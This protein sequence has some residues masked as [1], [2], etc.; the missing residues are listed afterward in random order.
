[1]HGSVLGIF[2]L[3]IVNRAEVAGRDV[4]EVGS[5][6]V[7]GSVR[8]ILAAHHPR[9]YLG[10]D[11]VDGPGVD[12]VLDAKQLAETFGPDSFDIVVCCET[13]EHVDDW[14][15]VMVNLVEVL[16]PGGALIITTRSVGFAY[17]HPPDTFRYT[18]ASFAAMAGRFALDVRILVDD[19]EFPGVFVK[20]RKPADWARPECYDLDDVP[21]ITRTPLPVKVLGL[22][23]YPDGTAYYRFS[24]PFTELLR[25]GHNVHIPGPAV[26]FI[27]TPLAADADVVVQQRAH[28]PD[29]WARLARLAGG[30]A[31]IYETDDHILAPD[32]SGLDGWLDP[33]LRAATLGCLR[34]ADLV[35]TSTEL[36]AEALRAH[37]DAE[38]VVLPDCVEAALLTVDPTRHHNRDDPDRE[39]VVWWAGANNHLQDMMVLHEPMRYLA[40]DR[41]DLHLMGRDFRPLLGGRGR[42]T[43]WRD[44]I[45][46]YYRTIDADIGL[47]PLVDTPFNRTRAPIKAL[48][49]A[50]LGVPVIASDVEPYRSFVIDGVT[51][52]LARTPGQWVSRIRELVHDADARRELGAKARQLAAQWTIEEHW[53]RWAAA[54]ERAASG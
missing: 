19:P 42:Y 4:L 10:V 34:A 36:L 27:D 26:E 32:P 2:A 46:A 25:R 43:R 53:P 15:A 31:L 28:T 7:N 23:G 9:S 45:W 39:P 11:V 48:E 29:A 50:A 47:I 40:E 38:V 16:R 3:G 54:Y 20:Y 13:M 24:Q 21:G 8:P 22:P 49:L 35:T 6:D 30:P 5:L 14:Q 41:F 44:D 37:T 33:D 52:Y 17:H 18:Q 12:L 1:M 51:G